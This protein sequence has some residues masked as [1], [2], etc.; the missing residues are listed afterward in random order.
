MHLGSARHRIHGSNAPE[1]IGQAVSSGCICMLKEDV[2]V[3]YER[4][5]VGTRTV[6]AH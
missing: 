6:V 3:L 2:I 1:A 5:K 4:A